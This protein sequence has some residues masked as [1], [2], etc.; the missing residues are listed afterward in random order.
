MAPH[1]FNTRLS[2]IATSPPTDKINA[3]LP[4]STAATTSLFK[5]RA[6]SKDKPSSAVDLRKVG[7]LDVGAASPTKGSLKFT[8]QGQLPLHAQNIAALQ[9]ILDK[10]VNYYATKYQHDPL[11]R[12]RMRQIYAGQCQL[13]DDI[14]RGLIDL[15]EI[16]QRVNQLATMN[17][18]A[19]N[20]LDD[21]GQFTEAAKTLLLLAATIYTLPSRQINALG[22][23]PNIVRV[24]TS[25][26]LQMVKYGYPAAAAGIQYTQW[27]VNFV[28]C[29]VQF[30]F[31]IL[32]PIQ[33]GSCQPRYVRAQ[34]FLQPVTPNVSSNEP[35][36]E[37]VALLLREP[38]VVEARLKVVNQ[39]VED[40]KTSPAIE[41]T[42]ETARADIA[43]RLGRLRTRL[44]R[45]VARETAR[46]QSVP[47]RTPHEESVVAC[48]G[49][50]DAAKALL[51]MKDTTR[52][53]S[54]KLRDTLTFLTEEIQFWTELQS[55]LP[56]A[57]PAAS[58]DD[59]ASDELGSGEA[60]SPILPTS[61]AFDLESALGSQVAASS[62]DRPAP[63]AMLALRA[64]LVQSF[65]LMSGFSELNTQSAAGSGA[66]RDRNYDNAL[67]AGL[68]L[69]PNIT[70]LTGAATVLANFYF[71]FFMD[72]ALLF[73]LVNQPWRYN[74]NLPGDMARDLESKLIRLNQL[75]FLLHSYT[76]PG[77]D[78]GPDPQQLDR[79][80]VRTA[81]VALKQLEETL[82]YD[83][84]LR[85]Q[86][87][88][89]YFVDLKTLNP[90]KATVITV[91][92]VLE[93]KGQGGTTFKR[94]SMEW[95]VVPSTYS[96]LNAHLLTL[97]SREA[98]QFFIEDLCNDTQAS[99]AV[100]D[101]VYLLLH[102]YENTQTALQHLAKKNLAGLFDDE[103][104]T[105][106]AQQMLA[107]CLMYAEHRTDIEESSQ[108][109]ERRFDE[110]ELELIL[111]G[112]QEMSRVAGLSETFTLM[113]C[114]QI[115]QKQIINGYGGFLA[116]PGGFTFFKAV[117]TLMAVLAEIYN[118]FTDTT[119]KSPTVIKLVGNLISL[120]GSLT[121][122]IV[123]ATVYGLFIAL[124]NQ[125][126]NEFKN[127][128]NNVN[129]AG[130]SY[131]TMGRGIHLS[132]D[133]MKGIQT[134]TE[135]LVT[136]A[137][138][139]VEA[140]AFDTSGD[141]A[142]FFTQCVIRFMPAQA[143]GTGQ[144]GRG[145]AS[146]KTQSREEADHAESSGQTI[147]SFDE[148]EEVRIPMEDEA[149]GPTGSASSQE[150]AETAPADET[151]GQAS[152]PKLKA[153]VPPL[154]YD[155]PIRMWQEFMLRTF[156]TVNFFKWREY[157]N[158]QGAELA[159]LPEDGLP[160]WIQA[161]LTQV[162]ALVEQL[163]AQEVSGEGNSPGEAGPSV[164]GDNPSPSPNAQD[165]DLDDDTQ[166]VMQALGRLKFVSYGVPFTPQ[167]R[168]D[169]VQTV[170]L[171]FDE[172]QP[173]AQKRVRK[174]WQKQ[175]QT[176]HEHIG[177]LEPRAP[178]RPGYEQ[179][180]EMLEELLKRTRAKATEQRKQP[181]GPSGRT[182][183][184]RRQAPSTAARDAQ[185]AGFVSTDKLAKAERRQRVADE[186]QHIQSGPPVDMTA[187]M[188]HWMAVHNAVVDRLNDAASRNAPLEEFQW[189][190]AAGMVVDLLDKLQKRQRP[191]PARPGLLPRPRVARA[192][193]SP[194]AGRRRPSRRC[195]R[196]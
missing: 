124:K 43:A 56:P 29:A 75:L 188:A 166:A 163:E 150:G 122:G 157:L 133:Y 84:Q 58:D 63:A 59:P 80:M 70:S 18:R 121:S 86:M 136:P 54:P 87:V 64:K 183:D 126:R 36:M 22:A 17:M 76:A 49:A 182:S 113:I 116:G 65:A 171:Q 14:E 27:G 108:A 144:E 152:P 129:I 89:S 176:L 51:L 137:V 79:N 189:R 123:I 193:R 32:L 33:N 167:E 154:P 9:K 1:R 132:G 91:S 138:P 24:F 191:A 184:A 117:F 11:Y 148:P 125:L 147:E 105:P 139:P 73:S 7:T 192:F 175:A 101:S 131:A 23:M 109:D 5:R 110:H 83:L 165:L 141:F 119:S 19:H 93:D 173:K 196:S 164:G 187:L 145:T 2:A 174:E 61:T 74:R 97:K 66:R 185:R 146:G 153:P 169:R 13:K 190:Q 40:W 4:D 15:P 155:N 30:A 96:R 31:T 44:E 194:Q 85:S 180:L 179:A 170:V 149:D 28:Y 41:E 50:M 8:E 26:V 142:S 186:L 20:I 106:K 69:V 34:T 6:R 71:G 118:K 82:K 127:D 100:R 55:A 57:T 162:M 98:R 77:P 21:R 3:M 68:S 159:E 48:D 38:S 99:H 53:I 16:Q 181:R 45:K 135:M 90:W 10:D 156:T 161:R 60:P 78:G 39:L 72:L 112:V 177:Q 81:Q 134:H 178:L 46:L 37:G 115:L 92:K 62:P 12:Q 151:A 95:H 168:K 128:P 172:L 104:L 25:L 158:A 140:A 88:L 102:Q 94:S 103:L 35:K 107:K 111:E 42:Q 114:F 67:S 120:T 47:E 160:G 143:D 130:V 195:C 52:V